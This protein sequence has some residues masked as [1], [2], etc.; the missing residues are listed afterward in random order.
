[1][2]ISYNMDMDFEQT[3]NMYFWMP[4]S[5]MLTFWMGLLG[6]LGPV[7][8]EEK[9][10]FI[11]LGWVFVISSQKVCMEYEIDVCRIYLFF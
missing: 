3:L 8:W 11:F 6:N 2:G 4:I 5:N 9:H 7:I 1:M 10:I